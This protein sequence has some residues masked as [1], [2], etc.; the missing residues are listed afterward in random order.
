MEKTY[1]HSANEKNRVGGGGEGYQPFA[2]LAID[3][4]ILPQLGRKL[5]CHGVAGGKAH[6]HHK[7]A[8]A[9]NPE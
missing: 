9:G 7:T 5:G 1:G 8:D 3:Q 6:G 4:L 2:F